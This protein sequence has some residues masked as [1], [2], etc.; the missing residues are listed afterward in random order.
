LLD[1]FLGTGGRPV[2]SR[3][4]YRRSCL[5]ASMMCQKSPNASP[6]SFLNQSAERPPTRGCVAPADGL[7]CPESTTTLIIG[8][9]PG[10]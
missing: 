9:R 7:R 8:L 4:I 3:S 5:K 10:G 2:Q 6:T 1:R